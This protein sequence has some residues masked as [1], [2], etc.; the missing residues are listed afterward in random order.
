MGSMSRMVKMNQE[1]KHPTSIALF[2]ETRVL[3]I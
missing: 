2:F 3:P 1:E